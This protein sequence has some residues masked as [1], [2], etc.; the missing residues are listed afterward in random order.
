M[1][2]TR[3]Y[4]SMIADTVRMNAYTEALRAAVKPGDIVD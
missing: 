1:Y 3:D 2:N 4:G